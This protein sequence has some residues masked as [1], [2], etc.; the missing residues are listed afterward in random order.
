MNRLKNSLFSKYISYRNRKYLFQ[1]HN[2]Y[3][4]LK[5]I[6]YYIL[7]NVDPHQSAV[8]FDIDDTILLNTE[9]INDNDGAIK[10][11]DI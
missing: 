5:P 1:N 9:T 4:G 10:N 7:S 8:V 6:L 11:P 3:S 2:L